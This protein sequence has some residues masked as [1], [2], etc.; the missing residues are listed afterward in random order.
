MKTADGP[1]PMVERA[2]RR[3]TTKDLNRLKDL[4]ESGQGD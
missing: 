3:A 1:L 2:M 4:L